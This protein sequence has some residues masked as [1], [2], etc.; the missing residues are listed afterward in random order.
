MALL[1]LGSNLV[2]NNQIN[3]GQFVGAEIVVL[4]ILSSVEKLIL[5]MET[6]Y[7]V[8]TGVEKIGKVVDLPLDSDK[9]ISYDEIDN[10]KGLALKLDKVSFKYADA[11]RTTICNLS[12]DIE[13]GERICISGYNGSGKATLSQLVSGLYTEF[14]GQITYNGFPLRNIKLDSLRRHIGNYSQLSDI[15]RGTIIENI[16]MGFKEISMQ[17]VIWAAQKAGLSPKIQGMKEGYETLLLPGGTNIPGSIRAKILLARAI[18][19]KPKLLIFEEF[20]SKLEP[21]DQAEIARF[22]TDESHPWTLVVVSNNPLVAQ[23]CDRTYILRR[24]IIEAEGSFEEIQKSPHFGPLFYNTNN[25][26]ALPT[27]SN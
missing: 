5:T 4:L 20:F 8:L 3:I 26:I 6:I 19:C 9:G 2:V 11:Q 7:D 16:S 21:E 18:A 14:Q 23:F 24:G 13:S 1:L 12:M 10:G 17:E 27:N 25:P 22:L 15:F